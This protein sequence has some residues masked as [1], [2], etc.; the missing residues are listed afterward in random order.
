[1]NCFFDFIYLQIIYFFRDF[2][3]NFI[4]EELDELR[5]TGE[6][7]GGLVKVTLSGNQEPQ[8][9]EIAPEAL[10]EGAEVLSDLVLAALKD[11]YQLSTGTMKQKMEDLTGGLGLPAGF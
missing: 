2:I 4:Q 3:Y 11:A 5:L 10:N 6:S 1:M 9:V 8:S 7:G